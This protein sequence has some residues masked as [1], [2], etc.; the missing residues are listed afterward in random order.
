M[1]VT[2]TEKKIG[3][4]IYIEVS[5]VPF[6]SCSTAWLF[7]ERGYLTQRSASFHLAA[8][9]NSVIALKSWNEKRQSVILLFFFLLLGE[10]VIGSRL[11]CS[12]LFSKALYCNMTLEGLYDDPQPPGPPWRGLPE[13]PTELHFSAF[14][15]LVSGAPALCHSVMQCQSCWLAFLTPDPLFGLGSVCCHLW[16]GCRYWPLISEHLCHPSSL[17]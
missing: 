16:S 3:S 2:L 5:F 4:K 11:G 15:P 9:A 1:S 13:T 17:T 14:F 8:A 10:W 6:S 12:F 7:F